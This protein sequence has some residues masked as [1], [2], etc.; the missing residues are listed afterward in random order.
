MKIKLTQTRDAVQTLHG[1]RLYSEE[2]VV[3]G[4]GHGFVDAESR[5]DALEVAKRRAIGLRPREP[6]RASITPG[7]AVMVQA[8]VDEEYG[9]VYR[10]SAA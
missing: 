1:F 3:V 6:D 10:R 4:S 9:A 5:N 8:F 2:G 7:S